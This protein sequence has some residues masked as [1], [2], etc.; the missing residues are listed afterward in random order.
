MKK[1]KHIIH[2][3]LSRRNIKKQ[4]EK[5]SREL[6][7]E[8]TFNDFL[9]WTCFLLSKVYGDPFDKTFNEYT[10]VEKYWSEILLDD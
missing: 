2:K 8:N 1:N 6:L 3:H 10:G 9:E 5:I 7:I 4:P